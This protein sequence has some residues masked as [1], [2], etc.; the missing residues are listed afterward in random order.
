MTRPIFPGYDEDAHWW[1]VGM[2]RL[3]HMLLASVTLAPGSVLE[4]GCGAFAFGREFAAAQPHHLV[5]GFDLDAQAL[6]Y[7][8]AQGD[9]ALMQADMHHLPLSANACAAVVALDAFDQQGVDLVDLLAESWRTLKPGGILLLRV[10]AYD[11]LR[12]PHDQAFGAGRRYTAS[13]LH[14]SLSWRLTSISTA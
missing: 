11:W 1:F 14:V 2:R 10:S 6:A 13:E 9:S 4:L 5:I 8:R 12:G 7:A 3:T